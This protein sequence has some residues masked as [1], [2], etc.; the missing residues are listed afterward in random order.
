MSELFNVQINHPM[1]SI[2]YIAENV[3]LDEAV[4]IAK[5]QSKIICPHAVFIVKIYQKGGTK[6]HESISY[7]DIVRRKLIKNKGEKYDNKKTME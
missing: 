1:F 4:K 2:H 5:E 7:Y 3:P 6:V